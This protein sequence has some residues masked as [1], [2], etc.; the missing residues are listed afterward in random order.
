MRRSRLRWLLEYA[1]VRGI[2]AA[3][4]PMPAGWRMR[5]GYFL[6]SLV[7]ALLPARR[8]IAL[9]N[10]ASAYPEKSEEWR[11]ATAKRS[12]QHLGR[13]AVEV[14]FLDSSRQSTAEIDGWNHLESAASGDRGYFLMSGHFGNWEL[15][16]NLQAA[17]GYPVSMITRPLDNPWLER[18]FSRLRESSGNRII[19]KRTAVREM[20]KGLKAG[21]QV[22]TAGQMKLRNGAP[23]TINNS[24]VPANS[25]TP[26]PA[27][28]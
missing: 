24:V 27:E 3:L 15:L 28:S 10:L 5:S 14:L 20:V 12:F 26:T 6:G 7:H 16:G 9:H 21:E 1:F 2:R 11:S 13:L 23:V 17:R 19:H 25:R 18:L 22:V 8:R 4:L